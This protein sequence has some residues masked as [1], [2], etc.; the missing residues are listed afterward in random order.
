MVMQLPAGVL[1]RLISLFLEGVS[2]PQRFA[3]A[4]RLLAEAFGAEQAVVV[5]WDRRGSW[6]SLR[7]A[8]TTSHGWQL[9]AD[10]S[11]APQLHWQRLAASVEAGRWHRFRVLHD[12]Q[13]LHGPELAGAAT[14]PPL[15]GLRLRDLS[16]ADGLLLLQ[17]TSGEPPDPNQL[18]APSGDLVKSLLSALELTARLRQ[19]NHRLACSN[20]L[21]DAIRLPLLL[22]DPS[23]RLLAANRHIQP[24]ME[25]TISS[26]G[27]R[28]ISLRGVSASKFSVAV[29]EASD[30]QSRRSGSVLLLGEVPARQ[31]LILPVVIRQPG[32]VER[33]ALVLVHAEPESQASAHTL[34]Q[35]I[36]GL[37]PAEA[38]LAMLIL[39]GGSP[40]DAATRLKVSVATIRTQLSAILKKTGSRKQAELVR[41]LAPLMVLHQPQAVSAET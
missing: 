18:P 39:E 29:R 17:L 32:R 2:H 33:G 15:M 10:D 27:R 13:H 22:L 24:L 19:L 14:Q 37:T 1:A 20:M 21:L 11:G 30:P 5:L 16:G 23:L 34:L 25:R 31:V 12:G 40:G 3:E 7:E 8:R 4:L 38:R 28:C 36:Y 41:Q 9:I 35:Q 26:S 6:T